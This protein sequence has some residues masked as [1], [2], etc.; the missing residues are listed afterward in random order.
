VGL[1]ASQAKLLSLTARISNNE[2]QAQF[3]TNSKVRLAEDSNEAAAE[4]MRALDSTNLQYASYDAQSN[5]AYQKLTAGAIMEYGDLKNQYG[6]INQYGQIYVSSEDIRNY[7]A[8]STLNDFLAC[9]GVKFVENPKYVVALEDLYGEKWHNYFNP[10]DREARLDNLNNTVPSIPLSIATRNADGVWTVNRNYTNPDYDYYQKFYNLRADW[11]ENNK[12]DD[13]SGYYGNYID[14]LGNLP[15]TNSPGA[16]PT[17]PDEPEA[18]SFADL[19]ASEVCYS[20]INPTS[21]GDMWHMDHNMNSFIWGANR[22]ATNSDA[23]GGYVESSTGIKVT[24]NV[25]TQRSVFGSGWVDDTKA[26]ALIAALKADAQDANPDVAA[27]AQEIIQDIIDL[28]CDLMVYYNSDNYSPAPS[29]TTHTLS[30]PNNVPVKT[31]QELFNRWR[32]IFY[33]PSTIDNPHS[34]TPHYQSSMTPVDGGPSAI[35]SKLDELATLKVQ[36]SYGTYMTDQA[37][38]EM[39]IDSWKQKW[40]GIY[41][42]YEAYLNNCERMNNEVKSAISRVGEPEIPNEKDPRCEWYT[43]LWYRMGSL[44]ETKGAPNSN[45][46]IQLDEKYMNNEAWLKYM[47]EIGN[48]SLEQVIFNETGSAET[49]S[50]AQREWKSIMYKNSS[51]I[52]EQEDKIAITKAEIKYEK[53]LREIQ[54]KDK[55]Y[56]SDLKKLDTQHNALQTEYE[57]LKS[58]IDKNVERSFKAFS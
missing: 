6:L 5:K 22:L 17:P 29:T 55:Q 23:I 13:A 7:E 19:A 38:Y 9:Y 35:N 4:Y 33:T 26:P 10:N 8:S 20:A 37:I 54:S 36:A 49:P 48:I 56:D 40:N 43:N 50:L 47:L 31:A 39:N 24:H 30:N 42:A 28:Y 57:S 25:T 32:D 21:S 18:V 44:S 11:Y 34:Q 52:S 2:L 41:N 27:K 51:D 15:E 12:D 58:V 45:K 3:I 14:I 1:S 53:A 46:Y 16:K